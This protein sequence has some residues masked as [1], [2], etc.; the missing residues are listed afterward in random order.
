M[1]AIKVLQ[2]YP[3]DMSIYD[4]R[5]NTLTL[6]KR[7]GWHGYE[8]ELLSHNPG[9]QL[10]EQVDILVGGGGQDSAQ[11]R[12]QDDL[13]KVAPQLRA[14]ASDGV[15]MLVICGLYQLFGHE[16]RTVGGEVIP[17]IDVL[18][19]HTVGG[20][21]R[22]I[23]NLT[24]ETDDFG[25]VVGYENHSGLTT[26]GSQARP[27][28]RVSGEWG[29][30]GTDGTEGAR[31]HNVIGTYLHGSVLPKNPR[32]A[33]WLLARAVEHAGQTWHPAELD[34]SLA[35]AA[36]KVAMSRPR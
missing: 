2:L 31:A 36:A 28:G 12:I 17:G 34:D 3:R 16:F 15:P 32:L 20:P 29:N 8:V 19:A 18:D 1:S 21:K 4:D 23:G 33:D 11:E 30:N 27:L 7:L 14:W 13:Q 5:G 35:I 26:L 9:D 6:T 25:K 10:P 22:L 24:V